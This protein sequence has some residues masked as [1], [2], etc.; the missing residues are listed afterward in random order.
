MIDPTMHAMAWRLDHQ[1]EQERRAA[2]RDLGDLAARVR[3]SR[4]WQVTRLAGRRR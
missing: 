4:W 3:R 1:D 2:E